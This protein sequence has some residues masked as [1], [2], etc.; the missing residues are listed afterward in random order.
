MTS[1]TNFY[2]DQGTDFSVD[3]D[4]YADDGSIMDI[5]N[6]TFSCDAKKIFS[7]S[8][9]FSF[10][11]SKISPSQGKLELFLNANNTVGVEPGKYQYDVL[12]TSNTD[13]TKILEGIVFIVSTVTGG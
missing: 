9:A 1:Q 6:L 4:F 10:S 7:S 13:V 5:T 12:M 8:K 11:T 2:V 3:I